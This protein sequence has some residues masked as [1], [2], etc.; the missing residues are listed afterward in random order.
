[1]WLWHFGVL[2][3][4]TETAGTLQ[5]H[6]LTTLAFYTILLRKNRRKLIDMEELLG[7]NQDLNQGPFQPTATGHLTTYALLVQIK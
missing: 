6:K 1:M 3:K 5:K 4:A 2:G 7:E